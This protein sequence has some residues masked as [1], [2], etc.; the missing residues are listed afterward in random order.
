MTTP[1]EHTG[2]MEQADSATEGT[3]QGLVERQER[4]ARYLLRAQQKRRRNFLLR[5]HSFSLRKE[6]A[7]NAY[8][9]GC[10]LFDGL[11]IPEI[12][13]VLP[14]PWGW[15]T[16]TGAF[17]AAIYAEWRAYRIFFSLPESSQE[18][19]NERT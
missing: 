17:I 5:A 12:V 19:V 3:P 10:I 2:R 4:F 16:A 9:V 14:S 6:F 13:L 15:V 18:P 1:P 7:R 11:I 8:L